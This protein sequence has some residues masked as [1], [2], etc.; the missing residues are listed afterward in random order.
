MRELGKATGISA[1]YTSR[2]EKGDRIP[3]L[4]LIHSLADYLG[5]T[6]EW[7][8]AGSNST[9]TVPQADLLMLRRENERLRLALERIEN[10]ADAARRRN[11]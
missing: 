6:R 11:P 7:L 9:S 4:Q 5:V 2:I 8:V 1:A 10:L 3:S